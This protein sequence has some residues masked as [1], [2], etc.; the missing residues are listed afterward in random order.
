MDP[1][2]QRLHDAI[3]SVVTT[4]NSE[5]LTRHPPGKWSAGEIFEHLYLTY[6]GSVKG[7][8]RTLESGVTG[9]RPSLKQR[10]MAFAVLEIGY[11]PEGVQAPAF[12]RP[13]GSA[14]QSV[15]TEIGPKIV[16]LDAIMV[17]C[18]AK[19][20]PRAKIFDHPFLGPFSV[21][22]WRKFHLRHGMH[23]LKQIER[24]RKLTPASLSKN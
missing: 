12:T 15:L 11:F 13:K 8:S 18:E 22:Q 7:L 16:E 1:H 10:V 19:F 9:K 2:L 3:R 17:D 21:A 24:L 14:L 20:G 4:L 5:E 6:T 23:H